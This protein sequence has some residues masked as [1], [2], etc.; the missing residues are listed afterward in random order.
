ME[1]S[2]V[3]IRA[4]AGCRKK[5]VAFHRLIKNK[6]FTD[7]KMVEEAIY[8]SKE[9]VKNSD[10]ILCIQDTTELK[11][12]VDLGRVREGL[13]P[14]AHS[15][16]KGF[17]LHPGLLVD[18]DDYSVLGLSGVKHWVRKE[19]IED[20]I[21]NKREA[22]KK[23][24]AECKRLQ[25]ED[26]SSFRWIEIA[27]K[28]KSDFLRK[29]KVT[30]IADRE[31]DIYEEWDRIPDEN[32]NL[33]TRA[34][35]DRN[36]SGGI[37][38][39][40]KLESITPSFCYS[41]DLSEVTGKRL[42]RI[43]KIEVSY[44]DIEILKSKNCKDKRAKN[45]VPLVGILVKEV[46]DGVPEKDRVLW[47]LMTSHKINNAEDARKIIIWYS[48]R[49]IIE[50]L[51]RTLKTQGINVESSQLE[52]AESLIKIS[53]SGLITAIKTM[54]LVQ[55]RDGQN[56]RKLSDV[57]QKEDSELLKTLNKRLEGKTGKQK[58]QYKSNSLAW[59]SWIIAR[60]GGWMGYDCERPPGPI[61]M[62]RGF[63]FFQKIK[64]GWMLEKDV[65]IP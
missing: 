3:C 42:K 20:S 27:E 35:K 54:Q 29:K 11:F 57:F 23:R 55:A 51:F 7:I 41:I 37:N 61:T 39:Y 14:L 30:I 52:S 21:L 15:F 38:L 19:N 4:I 64:F 34:S 59:G 17:F 40:E 45:S 49:W 16:C 46:T 65:C 28:C 9:A 5:E 33:I 43:S 48:K 1:K 25:V 12:D 31:S 63:D 8:H 53:I 36:L 24:N 60:L 58:N 47:R 44:T 18:A 50:Q 13:G 10:Q 22:K 62:K 32:V 6:K 2:S 26:K 56:N